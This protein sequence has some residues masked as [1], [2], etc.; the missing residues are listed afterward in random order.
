MD[1]L[2]E[3]EEDD[4]TNALINELIK[5]KCHKSK[6][7]SSNTDL[8]FVLFISDNITILIV[9]NSVYSLLT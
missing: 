6:G 8:E 1:G 7:N 3:E 5:N 4:N 9:D 2:A